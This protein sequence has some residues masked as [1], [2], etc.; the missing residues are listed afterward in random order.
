MPRDVPAYY[1]ALGPFRG[2]FETGKPCLMYHKLGP[3]PGGVRLKGLY[4]GKRL[5]ERQ[6]AEL[7]AAGYSTVGMGELAGKNGNVEKGIALTF[8]DGFENVLRHGLAP[9]AKNGFQAIEYLV[10]NRLGGANDW[11][12]PDGEVQERLM[13]AAQVRDWLAA[14]HEIGSH[15]LTHPHLSRLAPKA[16]KEEIFASK[17]KLEDLFSIPIRHFCHPY[18]DWNAAVLDLVVEADYE[19]ACT[20]A[21]GVNGAGTSPFELRR[22]TSR[23]RSINLKSLREKFTRAKR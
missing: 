23:H 19:T 15:S 10:A 9:L 5:F 7:R 1:T 2:L 3:R 6:L 18:G 8:D 13:D 22:I 21:F 11:D 20:T 4:V 16:A 17:K 14:G 12:L